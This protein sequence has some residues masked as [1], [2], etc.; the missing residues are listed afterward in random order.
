MLQCQNHACFHDDYGFETLGALVCRL[1]TK[2]ALG[3]GDE[4]ETSRVNLSLMDILTCL[5]WRVS[6][7]HPEAPKGWLGLSRVIESFISA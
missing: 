6:R 2:T 1:C 4:T 7:S 3:V 5:L